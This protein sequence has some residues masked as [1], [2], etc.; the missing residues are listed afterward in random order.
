MIFKSVEN[1]ETIGSAK[2]KITIKMIVANPAAHLIEV[3]I[4]SRLANQLPITAALHS[5]RSEILTV[6]NQ[7]AL[8]VK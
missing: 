5:D 1:T 4:D 6:I 3:E 2:I 7:D 8:Q